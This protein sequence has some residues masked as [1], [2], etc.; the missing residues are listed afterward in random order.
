MNKTE[1]FRL[2]SREYVS[3]TDYWITRPASLDHP[4]DH[5]VMFIT[6]RFPEKRDVF[7]SVSSC[8]IFWPEGWKIPDGIC[9]RNAVVSCRNPRLD[10]CKFF[11]DHCIT[12]LY[13]PDEMTECKGALVAK[14]AQIGEGTI[15]FPGAYISGEVTIGIDCFIAAGV[16]IMGRV[17]IGDRVRI[18]ENAVIGAD[19]LSTDRDENGRA[20]TM[21]Q[22]GSVVIEDDVQIGANTVI[23]RGAIDE[24]V[25]RK[26][27]KIDNL[28][29]ISH[30]VTIGEESFVVGETLL[31]GSASVGK[32]AQISGGCAIGNYVHIGDQALVG[33]GSVVTKDI[34][35][36]CVAYG[37]PA[38]LV[39]KRLEE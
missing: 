35:P 6:E 15:I 25:L 38:K 30:N 22:F 19:G 14:T 32:Q 3:D 37:S 26:G 36:K 17:H 34:P 39:R 23:A 7:Y 11:A 16:K 29:F 18:R 31:F 28:T 20:L 1:F 5:A 10:Y 13:Q 9:S 27:C 2:N 21:P 4:K 33:M 8:L 12:G 24:T